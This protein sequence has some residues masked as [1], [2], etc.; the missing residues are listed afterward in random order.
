LMHGGSRLEVT[1][2]MSESGF[3]F[4]SYNSFQLAFESIGAS[5]WQ[6]LSR[7]RHS[8]LAAGSLLESYFEYRANLSA[9]KE[10]TNEACRKVLGPYR[11]I[12]EESAHLHRKD[13]N[14]SVLLATI[15]ILDSFLSDALRFLPLYTPS[16]LPSDA[17]KRRE[18]ESEPDYI[19]RIVRRSR[20]FSSQGKRL[21]FLSER[22]AIELDQ[23]LLSTLKN[24]TDCRNEI[25]H[26]IGFYQFVIDAQRVIRAKDKPLPEATDADLMKVDMVVTEI[27][28]TILAG[29]SVS[30]FGRPPQVR[31]L[32]PELSALFN[33]RWKELIERNR[34]E[35]RAEEYPE[36]NWLCR[37]LSNPDTPW[38]G[39]DHYAFMI[40][41]TGLERYPALTKFLW[42]KR[43]GMTASI[44]ID[45]APLEELT[46]SRELLERMLSGRSI[47][48]KFH[49]DRQ[50]GF[51]YARFSL[52]GFADAWHEA[53]EKKK[54]VQTD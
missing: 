34:G 26:H 38:V 5:A 42:N 14:R 6:A 37:T 29:M 19:E 39:D 44:G 41:P 43:H 32:T 28:D 8:H 9:L 48:V 49:D 2:T 17:E 36:P 18:G 33:K 3:D 23:N 53:W 47:L 50:D 4:S 30:L 10:C 25:S 1:L 52:A 51:R 7:L 24:L 40:M 20:H 13:L 31:P 35:I 16:A 22:F 46:D 11:R 15:G 27:C 45:D 21:K 12:E 54:A